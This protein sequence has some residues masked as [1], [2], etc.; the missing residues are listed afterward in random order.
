MSEKCQLFSAGDLPRCDHE[1]HSPCAEGSVSAV[2]TRSPLAADSGHDYLVPGFLLAGRLSPIDASG[3]Q[4][5]FIRL[6]QPATVLSSRPTPRLFL[7]GRPRAVRFPP[8][9]YGPGAAHR[10]CCARRDATRSPHS[11][12]TRAP[13]VVAGP[14][15]ARGPAPP[16]APAAGGPG[17]CS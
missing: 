15:P 12:P 17:L 5:A 7:T 16:R 13:V 1:I 9:E 14:G 10:L 6:R 8:P 4:R 3:Q 11:L 2:P